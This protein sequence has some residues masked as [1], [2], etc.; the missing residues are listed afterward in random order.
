MISTLFSLILP[1]RSPTTRTERNNIGIIMARAKAVTSQMTDMGL[2]SSQLRDTPATDGTMDDQ[3]KSN[4][5]KVKSKKR[6]R[7]SAE[8][9]Q[10]LDPDKESART[11]LQMAGSG[12][13]DRTASYFSNDFAASQQLITESSSIRSP[14]LPNAEEIRA[15]PLDKRGSQRKPDR[16]GRRKRSGEAIFDYRSSEERTQKPRYSQLPATPFDQI[17]RSPSSPYE[18]NLSR[19]Q[20]ALDDILTDDE[21]AVFDKAFGTDIAPSEPNVTHH[22]IFSFSQQPS[23][24]SNQQGEMF[25]SYQLPNLV[26]TS[27]RAIGNQKK[28]KRDTPSVMVKAG[29]KQQPVANEAGQYILDRALQSFPI[30]SKGLSLAN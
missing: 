17:D 13:S 8:V 23:E 10:T 28:R 14:A 26:Y 21:T 15:G 19:S 2:T 18:E 6:K 3:P 30:T 5:T 25:P 20:H 7:K 29:G 4:R 9:D 1:G 12:I 27:P 16:Y 11:L 24:P 22:G